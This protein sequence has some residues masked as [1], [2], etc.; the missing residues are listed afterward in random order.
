MAYEFTGLFILLCFAVAIV[1]FLISAFSTKRTVVKG[2]VEW[3]WRILIIVVLVGVAYF[4]P[5]IR[6]RPIISVESTS[7]LVGVIADVLTLAGLFVVL[8]ARKT[9]GSNWSPLVVIKEKHELITSGPY[10][11]VRHP[12][13]SGILLMA[14]GAILWV[15]SPPLLIIF[16]VSAFGFWFKATREEKLLTEHFPKEYPEYKKK[17]RSALIPFVL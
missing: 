15:E 3:Y 10:A 4:F 17:V 6:A 16:I 11:Y 7:L 2:G 5:L 13:Y 14:L 1:Y 12:I 9:L 8:W